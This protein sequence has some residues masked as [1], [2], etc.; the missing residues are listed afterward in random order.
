M[1]NPFF[2]RPILN[3]PYDAPSRHW[4]LDGSG[5]PTQQVIAQRRRA[6][7]ISPIPKPKKRKE[8]Q[9][10]DLGG[11]EG[12]SSKEQQYA[13]TETITRLRTLVSQ[14]RDLRQTS[15]WNVTPE[16]AR[17]LQ[18]WRAHKFSGVRPFFCQVEAV[19]TV[20]WLA[21]VAPQIGKVGRAFLDHLDNASKAGEPRTAPAGPQA[22]DGRRQDHRDGDGDRV[23]DGERCP[24]AAGAEVH[25]RVS[26]RRA[27]DHDQGPAPRPPAE[28]P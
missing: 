7:F 24:P 16:T 6:E 9:Y 21:E 2:D 4:E 27:G 19:E 1:S 26:G 10:L 14:W 11:D 20:I 13:T 22:R 28:R 25:A 3:S 12:V 17:L 8:Q 5:Q 18:H 23:A 15:Q